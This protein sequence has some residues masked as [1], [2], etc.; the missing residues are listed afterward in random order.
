MKLLLFIFQGLVV[1]LIWRSGRRTR[2]A[3]RAQNVESGMRRDSDGGG[4]QHAAPDSTTYE[5]REI[6]KKILYIFNITEMKTTSV[7][8]MTLPQGLLRRKTQ[9]GGEMLQQRR[10]RRQ[11]R[12]EKKEEMEQKARRKD[13]KAKDQEKE[14]EEGKEAEEPRL[15]REQ[16][17]QPEVL[18]IQVYY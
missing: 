18:M 14:E 5:N 17:Q 6:Y 1:F 12:K 15:P 7:A 8:T 13:R 16:Q 11:N 9:E 4:S 3:R 10:K 2:R